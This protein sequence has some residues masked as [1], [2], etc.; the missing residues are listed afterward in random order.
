[1]V[2]VG[3]KLLRIQTGQRYVVENIIR[4]KRSGCLFKKDTFYELKNIESNLDLVVKN[5][6]IKREFK[7]Y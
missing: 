6:A 1:M 7:P 4:D 2:K 3:T 5:S